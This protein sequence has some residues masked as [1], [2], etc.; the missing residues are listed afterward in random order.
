MHRI[1]SGVT[2]G[3]TSGGEIKAREEGEKRGKFAGNER[4]RGMLV[5]VFA[6][7]VTYCVH[8]LGKAGSRVSVS[9]HRGNRRG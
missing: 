7:P 4:V 6:R 5:K 1:S 8:T 9:R 3:Y 2:I